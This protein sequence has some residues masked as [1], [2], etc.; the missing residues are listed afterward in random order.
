MK[1]LRNLMKAE[2]KH[3]MLLAFLLVIYL[4]F[5][6]QTPDAI[7]DLIDS[8]VGNVIIVLLALTVFISAGPLVGI[9]ALIAAHCLIKRSS[10]KTGTYYMKDNGRAEE[11]KMEVLK[12]Y[13]DFPKTLEEEVVANMVPL[14]R[15]PP[16]PNSN[17]KPVLDK[18]HDAAAVDY[19]GVI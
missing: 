6:V 2:E 1:Y 8:P 13:N 19:D 17:Y 14:V 16:A 3:Q 15:H 7:A 4:L 9:L 11:I 10:K 5:D 18:L 12:K